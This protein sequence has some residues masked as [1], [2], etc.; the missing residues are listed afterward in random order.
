MQ[1]ENNNLRAEAFRDQLDAARRNGDSL[2]DG[3]IIAAVARTV[4]DARTSSE[5]FNRAQS[6]L[7]EY[8]AERENVDRPS[9]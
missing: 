5:A 9:P 6:E 4:P 2:P 8:W 1:R 3:P 7:L